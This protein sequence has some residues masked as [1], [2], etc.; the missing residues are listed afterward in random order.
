MKT[1][2]IEGTGL[3][4]VVL[5]AGSLIEVAGVDVQLEA[6]MQFVTSKEHVGRIRRNANRG[7]MWADTC[8][9]MAVK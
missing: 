1:T 9:Y 4:H 7:E 2:E 5:P 8:R 3:V 6:E